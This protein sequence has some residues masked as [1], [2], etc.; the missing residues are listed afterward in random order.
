MPEQRY[1]E[2]HLHTAFSFLDG[3]SQADELVA[4]AVELGYH[5]L[6]VTDHDGLYGAMEFAQSAH[7]AGI[8]PITGAEVTLTDGTHLTLLAAT[9]RGYANLSQLLTE[10]HRMPDGAVSPQLS[11]FSGQPSAANRELQE[12][13]GSIHGDTTPLGGDNTLAI[14]GAQSS[15]PSPQLSAIRQYRASLP[16]AARFELRPIGKSKPLYRPE[17]REPRLDPALLATHGEG[18]ILLTGC[19]QGMLSHLIDAER[20][21][22]AEALL[23]QY[24]AWL[25]AD[26]VVVE[27][28]HNLVYGDTQRVARLVQLAEHVGVRYAATGNV[29]YHLQDR[30]RLQ[31]VLVAIR[32]R[33]TLDGCHRERRPNGQFH[34]RS[35]EEM[36]EL[37]ADYPRALETT[38]EIAERCLDFNLARD[39]A[40]TFPSY[41][42]DPGETPDD[43]LERVCRDAL[44]RRYTGNEEKALERLHDELAVI[45]KH[46]LAGFFLLYRDLLL[47][48]R[49]VADEVR[50]V[51][52]A[53]AESNLPPGRGRGSSVSSIVCYLIGLSHVDPL[54][55]DLFF[56]RFLNDEMTSV[57]DI[58]LDFPREI[59]ERLIERVYEV[60]GAD[61][62]ALVC[63]FSTYRLKSAVRDVG[64]AL[65]IPL[66]DLDKIAKLSDR[67]S[68]AQIDQELA[69][70]PAYASRKDAPPWRFLTEIAAQ[71][72]G[73]PRHVTQHVGG[74][75]VSSSP[76]SELVPI[77]P[78]A[79]EGRFICHWDKDSCDDARMVK[80]DFLALGML[81]LVEECV[82]LIA[83]HKETRVDL[84]R[85]DMA[86]A[87]I[88]D[89]ICAGDTI[90][91]FQIESR[92]QIQMLPRTRPRKLEDLI[93]QVAIV[94]PGPIIGGAVQP[95]VEHRRK[96]R[97]SF[98]PIEPFYDHP[99]LETVLAETHG[100][101]LYQ[102]QVLQV[103]MAF[104]GFSAGEA[105]GL[106]RAMTRK[107]SEEAMER[108]W[109]RFRDGAMATHDV[110][111]A[112]AE[113]VFAKLRGFASYG[114]PK[115]HAA[116]FAVLAYQS[117]W[118]KYYYPAEFMCALLNNQPMGF[119]PSHVLT[120]DAKRHGIRILAP[121]VNLSG[122]RCRVEGG[123]GIRIGLGYIESMGAEVAQRIMLERDAH[124][125][126]LSL[127]DFVR[128]VPLST[129]AAENLIA[130]GGFDRFGLGR[131]EALWQLGLFVPSQR[132][133]QTKR[134]ETDRGRQLPLMLPVA[135]DSVQLRPMGAWDQMAADYDVLG[136]SPRYH[137]LGLLRSK[138]P[139]RYVTTKDLET[140]PDGLTIQIAGLVVCRQRPG[141]AKGIQFLL[142]EDELGLV[143]VVVY[144][145]LYE[146]RRLVVRGE[147][148]ILVAGRLQK[149]ED[150]INIVATG[151]WA[152][153]EARHSFDTNELAAPS[154]RV[155][156]DPISTEAEP[157]VVA[158]HSHDYH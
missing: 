65:G 110:S 125:P 29:H 32:N 66:V 10:A 103:A 59:R 92:A 76:L 136:L 64:K 15:V 49:E 62:A 18:L 95:Y 114:F 2:L 25:G 16:E 47:L 5:A 37:F 117:C 20:F 109:E 71:L 82:E 90:G 121:D 68:A 51:S 3:A 60:Y 139:D 9:A 75:I 35:A 46:K 98:L 41:P 113:Q 61:R 134:P 70:I 40:Y 108:I 83:A 19:R 27:L 88:Y 48:A 73:H 150:T 149:K 116:A 105:E 91:V 123:N 38:L 112:Q 77:Q 131:R 85:I 17:E 84:S 31:D 43:R 96:V 80:I 24:V 7:A 140:L 130:V 4:R 155:L 13:D 30:H 81:S 97:T 120:N 86:D 156:E 132:F 119:Y 26:Q 36:A 148:F 152:L 154:T 107:R 129:E 94:R 50:G 137:P 78:A 22:E 39:L 158:P 52:S 23:R 45:A 100:V 93:V 143:N 12:V 55:H 153:E 115:A 146:E 144:P 157:A 89:M 87:K 72:A 6:A 57:P 142:L 58:D 138:L 133:G 33:T 28:Q 127:A 1:V 101:I 21:G 69:R 63:A 14:F 118:L 79:M 8:A 147:P 145:G 126:Y 106:R 104:A 34:L 53:R 11:A 122:V 128:R 102:E 44:L 42:T 56:G 67:H 111:P 99:C 135:Q 141:T 54:K 151:I 74:M 124:E